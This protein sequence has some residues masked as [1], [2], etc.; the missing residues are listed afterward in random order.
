RVTGLDRRVDAGGDRVAHGRALRREDVAAF[1]VQVKD[2]RQVR[3]A[4][5][6][7]LEP[8]DAARHTV[9]VAAEI[10]DAVMPLVA[11]ALVPRR[12]AALIVA[13][14][15]LR[16]RREQR[17]VRITR[18]QARC[19]DANDETLPRRGWSQLTYC[20]DLLPRLP[21]RRNRC[22]DPARAARR[23]SSR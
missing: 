3:A 11:A 4:V 20:H 13:A 22:R 1:S 10:D 14:A 15:A 9:L 6:V 23:P 21:R 5:R 7:V 18:M 2:E 17:L 12:D 8:F 16:Q 19:D